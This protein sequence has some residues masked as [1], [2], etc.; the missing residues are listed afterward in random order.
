RPAMRGGHE[1]A[2]ASSNPL[3]N[4]KR[5]PRPSS[6]RKAAHS[7]EELRFEGETTRIV[8]VADTHGRPHSALGA[9]IEE[10]APAHVFH[11]G[12]FGDLAVLRSLEKH[13]PVT[14]VRGH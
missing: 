13:A 8:A 2:T 5:E 6:A 12:D 4:P 3:P 14:A 10:L 9:R 11:A 1:R 7:R